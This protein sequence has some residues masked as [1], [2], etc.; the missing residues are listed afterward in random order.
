M[1][2]YVS[3]LWF[4]MVAKP[5]P[6]QFLFILIAMIYHDKFYIPWLYYQKWIIRMPNK[7]INEWFIVYIQW[8][9]IQ[10]TIRQNFKTN[11]NIISNFW[12]T[13]H[14]SWLIQ[15][16]LQ[17]IKWISVQKLFR[18]I[19]NFFLAKFKISMVKLLKS[20]NPK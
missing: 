13:I 6:C 1:I 15:I 14:N 11:A 18:A 8:I 5:W 3:S 9:I 10:C 17:C 16:F 20:F 19:L 12:N 2:C 7:W 4:V